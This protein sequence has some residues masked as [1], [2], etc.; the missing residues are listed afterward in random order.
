MGLIGDV[1]YYGGAALVAI[2]A[3]Q[4]WGLGVGLMVAGLF[5]VGVVAPRVWRRRN[6]AA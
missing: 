5:L 6:G 1:H 2:G 3:H 4:V